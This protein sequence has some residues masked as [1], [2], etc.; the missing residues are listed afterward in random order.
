M[1]NEFYPVPAICSGTITNK[2]NSSSWEV[3]IYSSPIGEFNGPIPAGL[4]YSPGG[5][6]NFKKGDYVKVMVTFL[7]GGPNLEYNSVAPQSEAWILGTFQEKQI[8]DK[9]IEPP[10]SGVDGNKVGFRHPF[11]KAGL[12]VSKSGHVSISTQG[13][14]FLYLR[15][16]GFGVLKNSLNQRAQNF[17]RVISHNKG[18]VVKDQFIKY[19]GGDSDEETNNSDPDSRYMLFRRFIPTTQDVN[20]WIST[21]EGSPAPLVPANNKFN[22]IN[23]SKECVFGR[24]VQKNDIRATYEAG[25]P[26]DHFIRLRVD[27]V[28]LDEK[29]SNSGAGATPAILG[30]LFKLRVSD[31]GEAELNVEG[32]GT[33][34]GN[35][36]SVS[37][38]MGK[39][40]IT[41]NSKEKI[42]ITHGENDTSNNSIVMDPNKGIDITAL[43][44][45]RVNNQEVVLKSFVDWM[46]KNQTQL[47]QVTSVGGPAPISPAALPEFILKEKLF[48][49]KG[50]FTS[51][52]T[53]APALGL[54]LEGDD[55]FSSV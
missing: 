27:K 38:K 48:G 11:S 21:Y 42:T 44:G 17:S 41:I 12:T 14:D 19:D 10:V 46:T 55:N 35:K 43:N 20:S 52:G 30:N 24:I 39:D 23:I 45:L 25:E 9:E 37:I 47:C 32:S 16:G 5:E 3:N 2:V 8:I 26:G 6:S 49:D 13:E 50:G 36:Y 29:S 51:I 28:S 40:G 34:E 1:F 18:M 31:E 7:F 53:S 33:P 4:I 54:I 22:E 15:N